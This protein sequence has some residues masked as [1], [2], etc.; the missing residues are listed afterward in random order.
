MSEIRLA[1]MGCDRDDFDGTSIKD[2]RAAGWRKDIVE[3]TSSPFYDGEWWTHLGYC[4]ECTVL[5][6]LATETD[7]KAGD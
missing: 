1:C 2:A 5:Y 4:P 6:Q 3:V 7:G